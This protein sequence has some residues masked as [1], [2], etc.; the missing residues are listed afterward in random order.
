MYQ[1]TN[2]YASIRV[3]ENCSIENWSSVHVVRLLFQNC[4]KY[5]KCKFYRIPLFDCSHKQSKLQNKRSLVHSLR[6]FQIV[7]FSF[8]YASNVPSS[9]SRV[10]RI[11]N[12]RESIRIIQK[13]DKKNVS[14]W[15]I[16][17]IKENLIRFA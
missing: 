12:S 15:W 9:R 14:L 6:S 17:R 4:D 16:Y 5:G 10:A 2:G 8:F 1:W 11:I 3:W 7:S 13:N